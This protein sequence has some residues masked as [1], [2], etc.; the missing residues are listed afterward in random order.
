MKKIF[1]IVAFF[2]ILAF[3]LALSLFSGTS[4]EHEQYPISS[5][6]Y[7]REVKSETV[8][9]ISNNPLRGK[10][11]TSQTQNNFGLSSIISSFFNFGPNNIFLDKQLIRFNIDYFYNLFGTLQ[12]VHQIRAP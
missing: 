9:L 10:L 5:S 12:R 6:D 1:N 7:V 8:V 3:T 2:F 4:I 11:S